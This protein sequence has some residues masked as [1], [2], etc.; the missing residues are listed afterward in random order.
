MKMTLEY[1]PIA[2]LLVRL[3]VGGLF[4]YAAIPKI[5]EP[6]AFATSIAHYDLL[7]NALVNVFALV[8]PWLEILCAVCLIVG[9]RI[10]TNALLTAAMMVMFTSA[11]AWAVAHGLKIDCGCFGEGSS[12]V[13]DVTKII[14]NLG[15]TACCVYLWIFPN[16]TLSLD[17]RLR[18]DA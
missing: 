4:A 3:F 10:R 15:I 7:P 18:E 6:L 17:G 14:K 8:I 2:G 1:L 5:A 9:Y 11:V 12:D 13:T 16:T